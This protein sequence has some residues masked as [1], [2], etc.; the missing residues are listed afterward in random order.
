VVRISKTQTKAQKLTPQK[1]D[2]VAELLISIFRGG[3]PTPTGALRVVDHPQT[4]SNE[5]VEPPSSMLE[6][7]GHLHWSLWGQLTNFKLF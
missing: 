5:I 1:S 4:K 6:M 2:G 7:I 3:Q